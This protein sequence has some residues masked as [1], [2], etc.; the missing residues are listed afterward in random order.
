MTIAEPILR[1]REPTQI[2]E[3]MEC[4]GIDL[5]CAAVARLGLAYTTIF[6]RCET[7]PSKQACANG[8][9]VRWGASFAPSFCPNTDILFEVA[10]E[11]PQLTTMATDPVKTRGPAA[12]VILRP[13]FIAIPAAGL[14]LG[15]AA[16][17][18]ELGG[19]SALIWA[20]FT[21]PVLAVLLLEIVAGLSRGIH[22]R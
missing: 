3:M 16:K 6:H 13:V 10:G 2:C 17:A 1:N 5:G 21:V 18:S 15:F 22:A 11:Q 7:C 4:L 9:I 12:G 19:W 8:W 20:A 14:A